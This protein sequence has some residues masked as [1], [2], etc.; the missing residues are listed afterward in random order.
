[1]E[2]ARPA[3]LKEQLREEAWEAKV[4]KRRGKNLSKAEGRE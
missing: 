4:E 3:W 2:A 1:V